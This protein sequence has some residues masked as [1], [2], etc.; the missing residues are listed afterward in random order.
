[1]NENNQRWFAL[2]GI[3]LLAFTAFL[4]VTIV[5]TAIPFIKQVFNAKILELQWV[6]NIYSMVL[7]MTMVAVG[8]F[9]DLFGRKKVF[10]IGVILFGIAALGA[11]FS[12][13]MEV[14]IF[15]RALQGLGASVLFVASASLISETFP[16]KEHNKAIGIYSGITGLG[17]AIG[18]F[19]GGLLIEWLDWRWVFWINLPLII[20]GSFL[21]I[22]SLKLPS[23]PKSDISIDWKGLVLII[24]GL[25]SFIYGIITAA[26]LGFHSYITWSTLVG[27]I[28]L[29]A[30]FITSERKNKNPL[31]DLEI[32]QN[33]MV[34]LAMLSS[35]LAGVAS[36][37]FM[38]FDPLYL[39]IL[40][41]FSA[42]KIGLFIAAIPLAQVIISFLFNSLQQW[43]GLIT[44]MYISIVTAF[45]AIFGHFFIDAS[46][47]MAMLLIPFMLLGVNWGLSNTGTIA[48]VNQ[49]VSKK[50]ISLAIGS[51]FM[52]WNMVG[53]I[54][55]AISSAV[56]HIKQ[57]SFLEAFHAVAI[58]NC[59]FALF[60]LLFTTYL[61][62]GRSQRKL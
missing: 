25:G 4:D 27:G 7:T 11:G 24:L 10:Y 20:T 17:L 61:V 32:F 44:L 31:L 2:L 42:L 48:I 62:F 43:L 60:V 28:L 23:H 13:N 9:A 51:V 8:R 39:N 45:L 30:L 58:L 53:S 52:I 1:M 33:K 5:N 35:S 59:I 21:C 14:M 19:C 36:F 34:L 18:P 12:P 41:H 16:I 6:S 55:L 57:S 56:F 3:S 38:F 29:L 47:N 50:K 40:R 37:V 46:T 49:V 26:D 54:F 22:Y 15:F